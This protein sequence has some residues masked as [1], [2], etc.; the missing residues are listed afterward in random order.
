MCVYPSTCDRY[1]Q[2]PATATA[3]NTVSVSESIQIH[4]SQVR[5]WRVYTAVYVE[6]FDADVVWIGAAI[7]PPFGRAKKAHDGCAR[8]DGNVRRAGVAADVDPR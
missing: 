3:A 8:G 1:A 4:L 2:H 6:P 7:S 5:R